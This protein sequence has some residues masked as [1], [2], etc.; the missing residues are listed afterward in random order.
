MREDALALFG[1]LDPARAAALR[2]ADRGQ[3]RRPEAGARGAVRHRAA[4]PGGGHPGAGRR[5]ADED[6]RHR[7][8][9]AE[10]IS[11]ELRDKLPASIALAGATSPAVAGDGLRDDVISALAESRISS[12]PRRKAVGAVINDG[13]DAFEPALKALV[14]GPRQGGEGGG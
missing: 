10:R 4:G 2:A 11:L 13:A 9:T 14:E 1:F 3:R 5:A 7:Q 6:S 8:K 12:G